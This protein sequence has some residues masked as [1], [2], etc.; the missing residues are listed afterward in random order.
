MLPSRPAPRSRSV[1]RSRPDEGRSRG[2]DDYERSA[3]APRSVRPQRS[4]A[5]IS[6]SRGRDRTERA[7]PIPSLPSSPKAD[8][9]PPRAWDR[10]DRDDN[11][12]RYRTRDSDTSVS[13][14]GSSLLGRMR[15]GRMSEASSRTSLDEDYDDYPKHRR[16]A[17]EAPQSL[18]SKQRGN[19]YS[20][21]PA[22][23]RRQTDEGQGQ[24]TRTRRVVEE[25]RYEGM[26]VC[27]KKRCIVLIASPQRMSTMNPRK[28]KSQV[29]DTTS[30]LALPMLPELS[31][32]V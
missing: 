20:E 16:Q 7:P 9:P 6:T 1:G 30:G 24:S 5:D 22:P 18:R 28:H 21:P 13:S 4:I 25:P 12:S 8:R 11:S 29:K 2:Y 15:N 3:P 17:S 31:P 10:V 14:A 23:R 27:V 26:I 19:G 32:S